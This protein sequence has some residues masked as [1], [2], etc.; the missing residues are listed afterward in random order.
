MTAAV[1]CDL[2]AGR[3]P[4]APALLIACDRVIAPTCKF[5][6]ALPHVNDMVHSKIEMGQFKGRRVRAIGGQDIP[7]NSGCSDRSKCAC[8]RVTGHSER[9]G[10]AELSYSDH[11]ERSDRSRER[12]DPNDHER[13]NLR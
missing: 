4:R 7:T 9:T 13:V 12:I 5:Y 3:T 2:V 8:R 10:P 1:V 6:L 11:S